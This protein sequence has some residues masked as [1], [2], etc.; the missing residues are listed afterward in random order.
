MAY[1][2]LIIRKDWKL[3]IH[4]LYE[5]LTLCLWI[6][7]FVHTFAGLQRKG[8]FESKNSAISCSQRSLLNHEINHR[9]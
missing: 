6:I 8:M 1:H 7:E 2:H 4:R 3:D 9:I 5:G